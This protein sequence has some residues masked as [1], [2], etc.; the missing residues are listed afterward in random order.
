M[1]PPHTTKT[2]AETH[3]ALW[4]RLAGM[5]KDTLALGAKKPE[6]HVSEPLR[7]VAEGLLCDCSPFIR[8]KG[9]RLPVAAP[10]LGGLAVQLG[11]ALAALELWQGLHTQMDTRFK[12]MMWRVGDTDLPVLR[13]NPPARALLPDTETPALRIKLARLTRERNGGIYRAGFE[14]GMAQR[15]G[16]PIPSNPFIPHGVAM[17]LS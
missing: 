4:L 17:G 7:I 12:C 8:Q 9:Q 6:A 5:H 14:A 15:K 10:D 11:Q 3:E 1:R 16:Q 13:L 2:L